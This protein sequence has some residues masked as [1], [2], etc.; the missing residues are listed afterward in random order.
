MGDDV[1]HLARDPPA[2]LGDG[3]GG[4]GLALLLGALRGLV[5]LGG[6]RG[7][8]AHHARPASHMQHAK[9][10]GKMWSPVT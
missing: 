3:A 5:Q 7:A 10:A 8:R 2:L 6:Q 4:V 9:M 1:V